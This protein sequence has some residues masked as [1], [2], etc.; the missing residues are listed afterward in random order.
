[1]GILFYAQACIRKPAADA[2]CGRAASSGK[3]SLLDR[4]G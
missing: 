4:I 2:A 3:S 1:M